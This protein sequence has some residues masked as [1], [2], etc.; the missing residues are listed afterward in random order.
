MLK[1]IIHTPLNLIEML[2][3]SIVSIIHICIFYYMIPTPI[4]QES[5]SKNDVK[6]RTCD[7]PPSS[8]YSSTYED[9]VFA[10]CYE[11]NAD[12]RLFFNSLRSTGYQG[13][14]YLITSQKYLKSYTSKLKD[15]I[16]CGLNTISIKSSYSDESNFKKYFDLEKYLSAP[17][18]SFSK[19]LIADPKRMVFFRDP[20]EIFYNANRV[21]SLKQNISSEDSRFFVSENSKCLSEF[22]YSYKSYYDPVFIA[23]GHLQVSR[24]LKIFLKEKYT[25]QCIL[26]AEKNNKENVYKNDKNSLN[27]IN[28]IVSWSQLGNVRE[29]YLQTIRFLALVPTNDKIAVNA[30]QVFEDS[31]LSSYNS[32]STE[33]TIPGIVIDYKDSNVFESFFKRICRIK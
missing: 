28:E 32:Q 25:E 23:G 33:V 8:E 15:E 21:Y 22:N 2:F 31:K 4:D 3:I 11:D 20:F 29:F 14:T 10:T 9:A 1:S 7:L 16:A 19:V 27:N 13:Q 12:L 17:S 5:I 6:C 30:N 18:K 24:V 26:E